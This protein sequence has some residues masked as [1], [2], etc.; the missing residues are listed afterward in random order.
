VRD[1]LRDLA[2]EGRTVL[3]SSHLIGEMTVLA[4]RLL[5]MDR[6]RLVADT[7]VRDLAATVD[8]GAGAPGS[9]DDPPRPDLIELAYLRLTGAL[10]AP[11]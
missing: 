8:A 10:E 1:V 4:D 11:R 2:A 9:P 7:T 6:G 5:V 3:V